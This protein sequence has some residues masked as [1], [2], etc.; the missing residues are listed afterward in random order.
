MN[1]PHPPAHP[2]KL[3]RALVW[4]RR[5]LRT[6]DHAALHHALKAARQVWCVFVFDRDILDALPGQT[7]SPSITFK[8]RSM[9]S[10]VYPKFRKA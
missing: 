9:L 3:D 6:D 5:D 8:V 10:S 4:L 2:V 1:K 7:A